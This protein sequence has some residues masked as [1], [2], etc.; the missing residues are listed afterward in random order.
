MSPAASQLLEAG[1]HLVRHGDYAFA[2][3]DCH[4]EGSPNEEHGCTELFH[5]CAC[6]G[7]ALMLVQ[8]PIRLVRAT[9]TEAMRAF[10]PTD[11]VAGLDDP[12][13]ALRPPIAAS[14]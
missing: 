14:A 11:D 1:I 6:H 13:P 4:T 7:S 5:R 9:E 2:E 10:Y 3:D 12:E 8:Q